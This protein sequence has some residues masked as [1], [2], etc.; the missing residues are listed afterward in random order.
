ML[1]LDSILIAF[2]CAFLSPYAVVAAPFAIQLDLGTFEDPGFPDELATPN[3]KINLS[4]ELDTEAL[5]PLFDGPDFGTLQWAT[6]WPLDNTSGKATVTG[7]SAGNGVYPITLA[8]DAFYWITYRKSWDELVVWMPNVDFQ[9][10]DYTFHIQA[11]KSSILLPG[12]SWEPI[13]FPKPFGADK[14]KSLTM[15]GYVS[16]P[17]NP[18]VNTYPEFSGV[19]LSGAFVPEPAS[20]TIFTLAA[21]G[22]GAIRR[23]R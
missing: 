14:V 23:R 11:V 10:L 4:I 15:T 12:S 6:D 17:R 1:K 2:A 22:L 7:A 19:S 5:T 16:G 21:L 18:N 20:L 9:F 8:Y 3:A 13:A